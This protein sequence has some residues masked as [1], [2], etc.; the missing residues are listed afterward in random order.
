M[1]ISGASEG[2]DNRNNEPKRVVIN[3]Q[4]KFTCEMQLMRSCWAYKF[5][6]G[7]ALWNRMRNHMRDNLIEIHY[8]TAH[9]ILLIKPSSNH[10]WLIKVRHVHRW[11]YIS[12]QTNKARFTMR[13]ERRR[14]LRLSILNSLL[15]FESSFSFCCANVCGSSGQLNFGLWLDRVDA[16]DKVYDN[17]PPNES[18]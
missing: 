16:N 14:A 9:E 18:R 7:R 15:S 11:I 4:I 6:L 10:N 3:K 8:A 2:A 12:R 13:K 1:C 17:C 5:T